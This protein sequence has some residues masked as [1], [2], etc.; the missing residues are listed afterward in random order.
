M[1]VK[2]VVLTSL[3]SL[4]NTCCS[5]PFLFSHK[6]D[7]PFLTVILTHSLSQYTPSFQTASQAPRTTTTTTKP[8]GH[9]EDFIMFSDHDEEDEGSVRGSDMEVETQAQQVWN[10]LFCFV[11]LHCCV[12]V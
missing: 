4:A 9:S 12:Y 5:F 2:A 8:R 1:N 3:S 10:T 11:F 6:Q 7:D